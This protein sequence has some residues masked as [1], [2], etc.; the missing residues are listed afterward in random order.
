MGTP[1][2]PTTL[3]LA[4][5]LGL[6]ALVA[7]ADDEASDEFTQPD[8]E[9]GSEGDGDGDGPD[10]ADP[11]VVWPLLDCDPLVP[12]YCAF[13][14]PNNVFS[15][16][17]PET[18][19]GRR[20][21][22]STDMI[23][24]GA[25]YQPDADVWLDSDG[26]SPASAL[27]A[28]FP[29][30]SVEGLATPLTIEASLAEDSKTIVINAET[31]ARVPHWAELDMS[32]GD[33]GR[34]T[35]II[36]PAVRLDPNT[37]YIV[38]IRGLVDSASETLG[39]SEGFAALRDISPSEDDTIEARRGLYADIFARLAGA[40]VARADLQLAWDFTTAGD[41]NITERMVHVRDEGLEM[42]EAGPQLV[43]TEVEVDPHPGIALRVRGDLLVP[44]YLDEPGPGGRMGFG[45]D[46]LPEPSGTTEYPFLALIPE[47]AFSEPAGLLQ[48]G[49]GLFGSLNDLEQ[50]LLTEMAIDYNFVV[51]STTW[52]G[53]AGE[54]IGHIV[55]LLQFAHLD[56]FVTIVDR[57]GQGVFNALAA[58][59]MMK[60]GAFADAPE[61]VG[62]NMEPLLL[63]TERAYFFGGSLGGIMGSTYM[64]LTTD[65][66]RAALAVPGQPFSMLLNRSEAF[67][68]LSTLSL[69]AYDDTLDLA[70]SLQLM[71]LLWDRAEPSGFSRHVID[72]PLPGTPAHEVVVLG[73]IGDH[74][75]TNFATHIMVR[76][77]GVPS[78]RPVNR[79][80]FG[81]DEVD[82][83][84]TGSA[85]I[86]F[87]FGLPPVPITNI[88]MT[89]GSDPHGALVDVPNA[90]VMV[91]QFLR[92]G[93]LETYCDGVCDPS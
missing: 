29:G 42:F 13:P 12:D 45:P 52:L 49:H 75:V 57:L 26:F 24:D 31:G 82:Q 83:P 33:D 30:A 3:L 7:C 64:A 44:L 53:M 76:E 69:L 37:R 47:Q 89:E 48:F 61:V 78:L 70:M 84:Y 93:T 27:L 55:G 43:I 36:Q 18:E 54:D 79:S 80:L 81:I 68:E 91:E 41:T 71:Q 92:T 6:A 63:D 50:G 32:H 51:F 56:D 10:E 74:L 15:M 17:D 62:P 40:G 73:A 8:T 35:F 60:G 39:A 58:M 20:L 22:F 59:R 86:E 90:F 21:A 1:L 77:L 14:F 72:D 67:V 25:D 2:G 9:S 65:I 66:E 38:A 46:G 4:T 5:S 19:T 85:F 88:P 16:E 87:D 11:E 23:P 34:R 28:Y